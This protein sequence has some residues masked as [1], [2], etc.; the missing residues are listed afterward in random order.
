M[1]IDQ[2]RSIRVN[3][4]D[5]ANSDHELLM[6][7]VGPQQAENTNGNEK[8][9]P[10]ETVA[11]MVDDIRVLSERLLKASS[12]RHELIGNFQPVSTAGMMGTRARA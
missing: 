2:L 9:A 6:K 4:N 11:S 5:V 10:P 1:F 3:L 8:C 12:S 7:L